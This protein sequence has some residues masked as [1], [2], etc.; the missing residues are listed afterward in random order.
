MKIFIG[1]DHAGKKLRK[2]IIEHL[3]KRNDIELIDCGTDREVANYATE[4][5]KVAENVAM[6]CGSFGI[7]VCGTGIGITI[8]ANKV[9]GI[10]AANVST[11]E[12]AQLSR[13]HNDS[14]VLGLGE[15]FIQKEVALEIVDVFLN[16]EF[17]NG[18]HLNRVDTIFDYE[19][20]CNC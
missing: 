11:V 5:I 1:S 18:R 19:D 20:S 3:K 12:M 9:K 8:A 6:K 13:Q 16:T 17:E 4:G 7:V 15:R 14:N 10:R 2:I